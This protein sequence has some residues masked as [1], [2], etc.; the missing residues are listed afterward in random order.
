MDVYGYI[1]VL[2]NYM[3]CTTEHSVRGNDLVCIYVCVSGICVSL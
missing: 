3:H 2:H 1:E